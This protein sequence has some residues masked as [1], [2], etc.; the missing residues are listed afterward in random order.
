MVDKVLAACPTSLSFSLDSSLHFAC[1]LGH[2][3]T[4]QSLLAHAS[5]APS[6]QD[7]A[8][9]RAAL[10]DDRTDLVDLLVQHEKFSFSDTAQASQAVKALCADG[11]ADTMASLLLGDKLDVGECALDALTQAV[12]SSEEQVVRVLLHD[13][14]VTSAVRECAGFTG[15]LGRLMDLQDFD[16]HSLLLSSRS[17]FL[18][19][20]D[21]PLSSHT[22][23]HLQ[24]MCID[25]NL[26]LMLVTPAPTSSSSCTAVFSESSCDVALLPDSLNTQAVALVRPYLRTAKAQLIDA[27]LS[28]DV[29]TSLVLGFLCGFPYV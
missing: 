5:I 1:V 11:C 13:P 9:L 19:L 26:A 6:A 4:V 27:G 24:Q 16:S 2:S 3:H 22:L 21:L 12:D 23:P 28:A 15:L 20:L 14:R 18:E 7:N 29:V 10:Q 8:A 17:A 25:V